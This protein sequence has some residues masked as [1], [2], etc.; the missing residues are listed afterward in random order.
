MPAIQWSEELSVKIPSIDKQH[1]I[2]IKLINK[3]HDAIDSGNTRQV[4]KVILTELTRYTEAHF[5]Y[6]E[7]LFTL[8]EYPESDKHKRSHEKLFAKVEHFKQA[9]DRDE[10]IYAEL[11]EF[12]NSWLYHH[13]LEEDM[14]Y[15]EHLVKHGAE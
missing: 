12:L 1:Q 2:L 14:G 15:A 10:D 3:L 6:E 7:T 5:I 11:V 4:L 8:H 13:I 9:L